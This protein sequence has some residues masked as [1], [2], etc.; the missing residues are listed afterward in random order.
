METH[1]INLN[2]RSDRLDKITNLATNAGVDFERLE[3]VDANLLDRK[4]YW[5]RFFYM[6]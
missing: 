1:I 6:V 2:R 5:T 4:K 3:A